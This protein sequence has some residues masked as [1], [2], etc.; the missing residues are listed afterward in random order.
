MAARVPLGQQLN[1][2]TTRAL[3]AEGREA[4]L[5]RELDQLKVSIHTVG[6]RVRDEQGWCRSGFNE[7]MRELGLPEAPERFV[8][9]VEVTAT[10]TVRVEVE[11]DILRDASFDETVE[12]VQAYLNAHPEDIVD[13]AEAYEW[14][15][16]DA[17]NHYISVDPQS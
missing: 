9:D 14:T 11:A 13:Q 12:G 1:A 15:I 4:A 8:V 5:R 3:E 10:Q 16:D 7:V 6:A 17:K 2:A